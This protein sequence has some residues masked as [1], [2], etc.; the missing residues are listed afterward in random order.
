M[1]ARSA[2][3][4]VEW[5]REHGV[6]LRY[7]QPVSVNTDDNASCLRLTRPTYPYKSLKIALPKGAL[8]NQ[9]SDQKQDSDLPG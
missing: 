8:P 1:S 2:A 3:D 4:A 5:C 9:F 6:E 7:I